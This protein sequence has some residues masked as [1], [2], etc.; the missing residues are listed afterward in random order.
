MGT[1]KSSVGRLLADQLHFDFLDTDELVESR[2]GKCIS[3]I[4]SSEGET[5]FRQ[6][7]LEVVAGLVA[8]HRAIIATGGGVGAS[9]VNLSSLK[10]HALVVC[11]WASPERIWERVRGQTHRPLLKDPDPLAKIR[12][13]LA[14]R[15]AC[16][17]QADVVMNTEAHSMTEV[18][19]QVVLQFNQARSL[20]R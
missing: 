11:L 3:E 7:E 17:K 13:L 2:A 10:E 12:Q 1:G 15:E 6:H 5:A 18:A 8:R 9:P 19:Q 20:Y 14:A 16:Y 4:F